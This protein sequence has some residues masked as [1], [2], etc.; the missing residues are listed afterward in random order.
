M[1]HSVFSLEPL[2]LCVVQLRSPFSVLLVAT[3]PHHQV[4]VFWVLQAE[5]ISLTI[6]FF[7][8]IFL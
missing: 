5:S 7:C 2:F 3:P 6:L 8:L 4:W 1:P